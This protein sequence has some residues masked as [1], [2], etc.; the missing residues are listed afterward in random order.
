[1]ASKCD[2]CGYKS[3]NMEPAGAI[4][5]FGRKITFHVTDPSDLSREVMKSDTCSIKIPEIDLEL[6]RGTMGGIYTTLEG[7]I[8]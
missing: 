7:L 4:S 1:M 8:R 2:E 5:K 6:S 3:A